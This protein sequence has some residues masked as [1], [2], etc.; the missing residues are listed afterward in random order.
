ME[1]QKSL[2]KSLD[3]ANREGKTETEFEWYHSK[4]WSP[5]L[6]EWKGEHELNRATH[7]PLFN[8]RCCI[9]TYFRFLHPWLPWR[10]CESLQLWAR[11]SL[12]FLK[13]PLSGIL[14]P[15]GEKKWGQHTKQW[16]PWWHFQ[17]HTLYFAHVHSAVGFSNPVFRGA[18]LFLPIYLQKWHET[19]PPIIN[20]WHIDFR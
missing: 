5:E 7:L 1:K 15:Q 19:E 3:W 18:M 16:S 20:G 11:T 8:C 17:K 13:L 6:T 4:I 2:K 12:A 10:I 14:W 9:N